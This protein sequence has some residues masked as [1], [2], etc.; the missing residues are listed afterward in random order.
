MIID[1]KKKSIIIIGSDIFD[2]NNKIINK[3]N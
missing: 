1:Y 3:I 2:E